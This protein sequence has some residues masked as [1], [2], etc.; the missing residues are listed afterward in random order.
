MMDNPSPVNLEEMV[1][2]IATVD[3]M[4]FRFA[5]FEKRLLFDARWNSDAGPLLTLAPR[6]TSAQE[7]FRNLQQLRP[8]F[9]LP[10]NIIAFAWGRTTPSLK[11]D[12]V[13]TAIE[14]RARSSGYPNTEK[15]P[16]SAGTPC[17]NRLEGDH[18]GLDA[19]GALDSR[20]GGRAAASGPRAKRM[21]APQRR[22]IDRARL[23]G[24]AAVG[25]L[26]DQHGVGGAH[27]P[28][29][30]SHAA[31]RSAG[32]TVGAGSTNGKPLRS[33]ATAVAL[34]S[35]SQDRR[36]AGRGR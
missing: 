2:T 4:V 6:V 27:P 25:G 14:E 11:L 35:A 31:P 15:S 32:Q 18:C 30:T 3:V 5:I 20:Y 19:A 33:W 17:N 21:G 8:M 13:W 22:G 34:D 29:L 9:P 36:T 12:G 1:R 24:R 28:R 26:A 23:S 10:H 7:R 16:S